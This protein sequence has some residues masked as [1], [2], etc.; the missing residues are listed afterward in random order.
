MVLMNISVSDAL[1]VLRLVLA[2]VFFVMI[3][4]LNRYAG[5]PEMP[6]PRMLGTLALVLLIVSLCT[7]YLDGYLARW[8]KSESDLGRFADPLVDKILICG[9]LVMFLGDPRG[10]IDGV[11]KEWMVVLVISRELLVQGVRAAMEKRGVEFSA[12]LW[13]KLKMVIQSITVVLI[14]IHVLALVET[15]WF[16]MITYIFVWGMIAATVISGLIYFYQAAGLLNED[17]F[18]RAN[19]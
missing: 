9:S 17:D 5:V 11:L 8:M 2:M 13:G 15:Y 16:A 12:S 3:A 19:V 1:T 4:I 14:L 18:H 6:P 10:R 7:D